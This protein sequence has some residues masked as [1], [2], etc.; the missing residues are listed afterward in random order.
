VTQAYPG[1]VYCAF[2]IWEHKSRFD[3]SIAPRITIT[4]IGYNHF[5]IFASEF[6]FTFH[7]FEHSFIFLV[8]PQT[9]FSGEALWP[10]VTLEIGSL[11]QRVKITIHFLIKANNNSQLWQPSPRYTSHAAIF[12]HVKYPVTKQQLGFYSSDKKYENASVHSSKTHNYPN[13]SE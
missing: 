2:G 11:D 4:P 9:F 3:T 7:D 10:A 6:V 12:K 1:S 8:E 13:I 5:R